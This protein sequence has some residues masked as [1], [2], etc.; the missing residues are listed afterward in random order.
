MSGSKNMFAHPPNKTAEF[1]GRNMK[2]AEAE[3]LLS[4]F[5]LIRQLTALAL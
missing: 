5:V 2:K 3:H 4:T 1:E